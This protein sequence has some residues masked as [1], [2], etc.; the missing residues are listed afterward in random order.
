MFG[1][2]IVNESKYTQLPILKSFLNIWH[3]RVVRKPFKV[4]PVQLSVSPFLQPNYR[5]EFIIR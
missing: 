5:M 1:F 2:K 3:T 4:K